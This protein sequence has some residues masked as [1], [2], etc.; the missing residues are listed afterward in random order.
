MG[1]LGDTKEERRWATA[2]KIDT[3][4]QSVS[5]MQRVKGWVWH[6]S[7]GKPNPGTE[8]AMRRATMKARRSEQ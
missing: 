3:D 8:A 5:P 7:T 2:K 4:E 6:S 1:N